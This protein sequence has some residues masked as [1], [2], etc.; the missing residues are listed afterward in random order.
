MKN[1][2]LLFAISL[3]SVAFIPKQEAA[4]ITSVSH[5]Q[6]GDVVCWTYSATDNVDCVV[7]EVKSKA[8]GDVFKTTVGSDGKNCLGY[9]PSGTGCNTYP[10][11]GAKG[12]TYRLK[13]I[14]TDWSSFYSNEVSL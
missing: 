4:T 11:N 13:V 6:A 7:M 14:R 12:R 9:G 8:T 10:F 3:A 5:T 1:L 2:I